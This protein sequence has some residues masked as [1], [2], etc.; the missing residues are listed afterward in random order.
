MRSRVGTNG[1]VTIPKLVRQYLGLKAGSE[2]DFQLSA[3]GEVVLVAV[4][5]QKPVS[6]FERLRGHAGPGLSTDA[7]MA[8]TRG[9][10]DR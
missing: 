8:M 1:R 9:S 6:R 5:A 10:K 2:V 7:I 3:K 4:N